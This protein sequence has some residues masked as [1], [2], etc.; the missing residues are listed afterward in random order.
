MPNYPLSVYS[1]RVEWGGTRVDFTEVTGLDI[2][3]E[4]IQIRNGSSPSDTVSVM[5]GLEKFNTVT[6]KRTVKKGDHEF[7]TWMNT[8]QGNT[9]ERRDVN[10]SLLDENHN[11]A[12]TW[13]LVNAFPIRYSA[14]DFKSFQNS[15]AIEELELVHE[16]L[17]IV[18]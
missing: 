12:I 14:P 1:F 2:F 11:P 9:I 3:I 7:Y 8:K 13:K 17:S 6:L 10:I 4:P 15:A 18:S 5:P 16:G